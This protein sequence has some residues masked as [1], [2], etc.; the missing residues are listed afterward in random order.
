MSNIS[1]HQELLG[2]TKPHRFFSLKTENAFR[3]GHDS[4]RNNHWWKSWNHP[5]SP[6]NQEDEE[7]LVL[8]VFLSALCVCVAFPF[9]GKSRCLLEVVSPAFTFLIHMQHIICF[10]SLSPIPSSP[11]ACFPA[12]SNKRCWSPPAICKSLLENTADYQE[13]LLFP[14]KIK[15][16]WDWER[17]QMLQQPIGVPKTSLE[18]RF[19]CARVVTTAFTLLWRW[20]GGV[21]G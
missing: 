3:F 9:L 12:A 7:K 6:A 4:N 5:G 1:N 11:P 13:N 17:N 21:L 2:P 20:F 15:V 19:I 10:S 16:R 14:I 18:G 8:V